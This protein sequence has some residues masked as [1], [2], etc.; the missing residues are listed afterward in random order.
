I[1]A[2]PHGSDYEAQR[3][4]ARVEKLDKVRKEAADTLSSYGWVDKNKGIVHV[5]IERAMELTIGELATRKPTP[6]GPI[7]TPEPVTPPAP[8]GAPADNRAPPSPATS[9]TPSKTP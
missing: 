7:A 6:A 8:A 5:P 1:S 4:K 2:M 3:A 9:A